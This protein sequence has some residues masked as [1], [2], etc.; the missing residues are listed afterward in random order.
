[1]KTFTPGR[2]LLAWY[3]FEVDY[4]N[5]LIS[6]FVSVIRSSNDTINFKMRKWL[7]SN[8]DQPPGIRRA[9]VIL[10]IWHW[11]ENGHDWA[12][13]RFKVEFSLD[14]RLLCFMRQAH[15]FVVFAWPHHK[16]SPT[17]NDPQNEPQM[18]PRVGPQI[19]PWKS[20]GRRGRQ[21]V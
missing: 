16:W 15:G 6:L 5:L 18:I 14:K 11:R 17:R 1:M 4:C 7:I 20:Y 13:T 2:V 21:G 8:P 10:W 19:F 9:L 3:K 12:K